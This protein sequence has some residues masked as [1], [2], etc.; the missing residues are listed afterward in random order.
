MIP[1]NP[2]AVAPVNP[3][4]VIVTDVPT[5]PLVGRNLVIA[6]VGDGLTVND[7]GVKVAVLAVPPGVVTVI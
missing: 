2:T 5:G 7:D 4:P 1:W 6:G 3:V